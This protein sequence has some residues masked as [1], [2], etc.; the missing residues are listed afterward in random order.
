MNTLV[1]FSAVS[2]SL[3]ARPN[4]GSPIEY[5]QLTQNKPGVQ[6]PRLTI[7]PFL[8]LFVGQQK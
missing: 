4:W 7:A 1:R 6:C 3:N 2:E 8:G 5:R